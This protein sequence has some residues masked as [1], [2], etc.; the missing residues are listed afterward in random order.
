MSASRLLEIL[1]GTPPVHLDIVRIAQEN[2]LPD[3]NID[4]QSMNADPE[5]LRRAV[6]QLDSHI[7]GIQAVLKKL[8]PKARA[9]R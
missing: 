6:D 1:S 4:Y 9:H 8:M 2:L 5:A 3:G 7:A